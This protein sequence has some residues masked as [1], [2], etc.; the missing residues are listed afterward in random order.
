MLIL[1]TFF[2]FGFSVTY[3]GIGVTVFFVTVSNPV[4][5]LAGVVA[6]GY[7]LYTKTK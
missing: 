7:Y 2:R 5:F 1:F 4:L 3:A 6:A